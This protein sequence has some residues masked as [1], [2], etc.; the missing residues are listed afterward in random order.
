MEIAI[1]HVEDGRYQY[2]LSFISDAVNDTC[3]C[4][5][6]FGKEIKM[7]NRNAMMR[8]FVFVIIGSIMDRTYVSVY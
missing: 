5:S 7:T 3:V 4:L 8:M 2:M 1:T 6:M